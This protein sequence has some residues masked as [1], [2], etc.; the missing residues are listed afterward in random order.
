MKETVKCL[1][2]KKVLNEEESIKM[3]TDITTRLSKRTL[4]IKLVITRAK[5]GKNSPVIF[6]KNCLEKHVISIKNAL[7]K[8]LNNLKGV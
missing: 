2:C 3:K 1:L 4:L 7:W 6:C 8:A 5:K